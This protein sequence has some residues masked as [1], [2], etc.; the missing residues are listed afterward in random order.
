MGHRVSRRDSLKILRPIGTTSL[1]TE[2]SQCR[3][4]SCELALAN[5]YSFGNDDAESPFK[6]FK[7]FVPSKGTLITKKSETYINAKGLNSYRNK[8]KSGTK[9]FIP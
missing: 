2:L 9:F 1:F 7:L 8:K 6:M 5:Q 4:V 3:G